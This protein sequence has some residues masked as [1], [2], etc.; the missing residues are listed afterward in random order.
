MTSNDRLHALDAVRAF[1]LLAGIVLH[2][3]M[4]FFLP[5]PALDSSQ[6]ATLAILF[7]VIHIFRMSAFYLIAGFFARMLLERRGVRAFVRDRA[8]R[9][10][11]PMIG[12]WIVLAPLLVGTIIWG[13]TRTFGSELPEALQP[14]QTRFP[15]MHLWFLYYLSLFYLLALAAVWLADTAMDRQGRL[16]AALDRVVAAVSA[17][18]FAPLLFAA[19]LCAVL[20]FDASWQLW[21]GIPT[22]DQGFAPQ[23]PAMVGFGTAFLVG[24]FVH[25]QLAV[26]RE[27]LTR[28]PVHL[29]LA[30]GLTVAA[31]VL[32]GGM[33]HWTAVVEPTAFDGPAWIRFA[34]AVCYT[35]AVWYWSF[36]IVG[37]AMQFCAQQNALRRYIADSSYWL[38]LAHLPLVFFLQV[39]FAQLPLHWSLKF[40]LILAIAMTVL[41]AT[42]HYWVRFTWL[43]ALLNG[44]RHPRAAAPLPLDQARRLRGSGWSGDLDEMRKDR[45]S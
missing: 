43:G 27:W 41:L 17:S 39:L 22:P 30:I 19:P 9:I 38:Y 25:R 23:L 14:G 8:K 45:L 5:I 29:A 34:Y 21:G 31:L 3:T 10:L 20:Y 1:A 33:P 35:L 6:S 44:R 18:Y 7:Y 37:V 28:W 40:P 4:S 12:G 16:R 13:V 42:Y 36:A 24:W 11:V 32:L 2:A 15:L 26:L